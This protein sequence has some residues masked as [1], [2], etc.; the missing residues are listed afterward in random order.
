MSYTTLYKVPESGEIVVSREF[1]NAFRGGYLI[2]ENL[3][4]RYLG[5]NS[6]ALLLLHDG[7]ED[8]WK[9]A[10]RGD[11][12]WAHKVA[13]MTTFDGVMVRRENLPRLIDAL[14]QYARDFIDPG[15]IPEQIEALRELVD[16]E[17]CFAACWQQTSV[18]SAW[19]VSLPNDE[20]R[21][22][23]VSRDTWHWFLFDEV[24]RNG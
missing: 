23:D 17:D 4:K 7:M 2:W 3:A 16:D 5:V 14:E 22:Y 20:T 15:H 1:H 9:L 12:P 13:L 6:V 19:S 24:M 10:E 11:V 8:V 21:M 18:T